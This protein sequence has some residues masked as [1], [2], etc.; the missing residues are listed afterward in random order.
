MSAAPN[1]FIPI[2]DA[3]G[4]HIATRDTQTGL[5]WAPVGDKLHDTQQAA[6]K[7]AAKL[8][9]LGGGWRLPSIDE[10]CTLIDLAVH[11]PAIDIDAFPFVEADWYWSSTEAAWSSAS[12]WGVYFDYG[13][14]GSGGRGGS[15]YALAVRRAGPQAD[16]TRK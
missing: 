5:E 9:L 13:G 2:L 6:E 11:D 8:A 12:A 15:G 10:L 16:T 3:D 4:N 14:V 1:R 7:A